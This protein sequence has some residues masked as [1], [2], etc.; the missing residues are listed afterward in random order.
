MIQSTPLLRNF[1]SQLVSVIPSEERV[2]QAAI[3]GNLEEIAESTALVLAENFIR[4]GTKVSIDCNLR[5]LR[6]VAE[7][8]VLNEWLGFFVEIRLDADSRWSRRWFTPQHLL[9]VATPH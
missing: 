4:P 2:P 8:C 7:S 1:C 3:S 6:G 5:Q 9:T